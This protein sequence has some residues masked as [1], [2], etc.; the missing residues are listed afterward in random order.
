MKSFNNSEN[1]IILGALTFDEIL[2]QDFETAVGEKAQADSA[3]MRLS[4]WAKSSASGDWGAF[5]RRLARDGLKLEKILERFANPKKRNQDLHYQWA[6]DA[7][8]ILKALQQDKG[9]AFELDLAVHSPVAFQDLILPI[10]NFA[11]DELK[12]LV[13]DEALAYFTIQARTD[14]NKAFLK[15]ISELLSPLLY[16][17]FI[18]ELK[19][20]TPD[21][22]L[23]PSDADTKENHYKRFINELRGGNLESLLI[24]KPV[25]LRLIAVSTRQ[26]V[27]STSKLM[28]RFLNDFKLIRDNLL[29]KNNALKVSA[30]EGNLSD[31]H[32]GG[33]VVQI[34]SFT[35]GSKV[36]YK[37]K[38][39]GVDVVLVDLITYL[40]AQNPPVLLKIPN[41]IG[42]DGYGWVEFISHESCNSSQDFNIFYERY[43][44]WLIIFHLLAAEDMHFENFI[45]CGS[46]PVPVD[47]ETILQ[48]SNHELEL[49]EP[50]SSALNH[51]LDK[52][53]NSVLRIGMLPSFAKLT[54]NRIKDVGTLDSTASTLTF[55]G[56]KNINTNGMR[57]T[58]FEIKEILSNIAHVDSNYAKFGDYR[59]DFIQG[60]KQYAFFLMGQKDSPYITKL[61][62]SF[63]KLPVRK[64]LRPTEFYSKLLR[65]LKD[66]IAMDDGVSWSVQADFLARFG[67][68]DS[69]TTLLWP[70]QKSERT[71]LL[72]LNIPYFTTQTDGHFL[73]DAFGNSIEINATSG[74]KRAQ[75]RWKNLTKEEIDWQVEVIE[76]STSFV[77]SS[78]FNKA[79]LRLR[80]YSYTRVLQSAKDISGNDL[81]VAELQN[82]VDQIE[83]FSFQDETSICWLG[84]DWLDDSEI[85]QIAPLREDL[86][87]GTTGLAL[88]LAAHHNQFK[89]HKSKKLLDKILYELRKSIY[90]DN[91]AY[92]ARSLGIGGMSGIGSVIY[93]LTN[94]ASLLD[95]K[96]LLEDAIEAS[97]LLTNELIDSDQ[98]LD[99]VSGSAGAIVCLLAL[100]RKTQSQEVLEKAIR[101]GEH[102]LNSPRVG[103]IGYRS[104]ASISNKVALNGMSHGAAGYSYALT[105]LSLISNRQDFAEA[106]RECLALETS[107]YDYTLQ[108][109]PTQNGHEN[110]EPL[111]TMICQWC[112]GA[113]GIGLARIA[114]VK[115]GSP[116]KFKESDIK[117][118]IDCVVKNWPNVSDTLCCGTLGGIELLNEAGN[119]LD[120]S[121]LK[122]LYKTRLLE[123]FS[124]RQ[125][126]GYYALK[127]EYIQYNLS[128]FR[129]ITGVGYTLLRYLNPHLPNVLILE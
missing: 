57:W 59:P 111:K 36:V 94:I 100:F 3:A 85:A 102:L 63:S 17:L 117:N 50:E 89:D 77:L 66:P 23:L 101:C 52:I 71:S 68:R 108:N 84:F 45:A 106:A 65:R 32:N 128:L 24:K 6:M 43:G 49:G 114:E 67:D 81:V 27:L 97:N 119:L 64:V 22:K 118:A 46:N 56:W 9:E 58:H 28:N 107:N 7:R 4:A 38:D 103:S 72:S 18:K 113:P 83:I 48:V 70:L 120:D 104:W 105:M 39:L 121:I 86:Y 112:H 51:A 62:H 21:G 13:S 78:S 11:I 99:I 60:F 29:N 82:M 25:L 91:S 129:G 33:Q 95:D 73:S 16:S 61:W 31:P 79:D 126:A 34:L 12:I 75:E 1:K 115:A 69:K 40:N 44:A 5:S 54:K 122:D 96:S 10:L 116:L 55:P 41:V 92:W 14:L 88:F 110:G 80:N 47:L 125:E 37:P 98:N 124:T 15:Q 2:S 42:C 26:W 20:N 76:V 19:K 93:A 127:T 35:N 109:W 123:V 8:F 87:L 53:R 74:L 90:S 30:I